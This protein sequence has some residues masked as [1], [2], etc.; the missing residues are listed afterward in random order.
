MKTKLATAILLAGMLH[1]GNASAL[2]LGDI[3]VASQLNQHFDAEIPFVNVAGLDSSQIIVNLA[4]AADFQRADVERPYFLNS[5]EFR[6]ERDARGRQVLKLTTPDVL[7]EPYLNFLLEVRWPSGRMLRE[8]MVLLD[9]PIYSA[10]D[11]AR[12]ASSARRTASVRKPTVRTRFEPTGAAAASRMRTTQ[13]GGGSTYTVR[14]NDSLWKIAKATMPGLD[15]NQAML[16]LQQENP[17]AFINGNINL[18]KRGAV[19]RLPGASDVQSVSRETANRVASAAAK[20]WRSQSS[21]LPKDMRPIQ[22]ASRQV[23]SNTTTPGQTTGRLTLSSENTTVAD[24]LPRRGGTP[25]SSSGSNSGSSRVTKA[26]ASI[27]GSGE[28][29]QLQSELASS[30]ENLDRASL[31][32][33]SLVE[34]I[35]EVESKFDDL[36]RLLKLKDREL[37]S[38]RAALEQRQAMLES[39]EI[40]QTSN[41]FADSAAVPGVTPQPAPVV[42]KQEKGFLQNLADSLSTSVTGLLMAIGGLGIVLAGLVAWLF[43]RKKDDYTATVF[44]A[45]AAMDYD[46]EFEPADPGAATLAAVDPAN[47]ASVPESSEQFDEQFERSFDGSDDL[48]GADGAAQGIADAEELPEDPLAEADIY[49]AYG[50][51]DQAVAMLEKAIEQDP[52]RTDLRM[53]LLEVYDEIGDSAQ[54]EIQKAQILTLEPGME[55]E[56]NDLLGG[57]GLAAEASEEAADLDLDINSNLEDGAAQQSAPAQVDSDDLEDEVATKLDLA[58]AYIDMGDYDGAREILSEVVE[59]GSDMQRDEAREMLA[60]FG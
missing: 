9:L 55:G 59:E 13:S 7:R 45:P 40:P 1:A 22:D 60:R 27:P 44:E 29:S 2:G 37:E 25:A 57:V 35:G 51:N 47:D 16:A 54:V 10:R 8:Y 26:I 3:D 48:P 24:R 19:L 31:E 30:L 56:I 58:R 4:S 6:V 23:A 34:R 42:A 43:A 12:P 50:R 53:K 5:I 38:V 32:N 52:L 33:Q 46:D 11:T 36:E 20:S 28:I 15:V 39:G 17:D 21:Q 41:S 49:L 18:L 14:S